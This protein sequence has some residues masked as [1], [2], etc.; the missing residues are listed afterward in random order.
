MNIKNTKYI[1]NNMPNTVSVLLK[2]KHGVG[3]S[4]SVQQVAIENGWDFYDVRLSQCEVGDIKG[5]PYRDG[6][7]MKFA[8][9]EWFPKDPNSKGILF[10]DELNRA[11]KDVLQAVFELCLDRRLDGTPLPEGWRVVAAINAD[12]EYDVVELDP[13]LA[14]RWFHIDFEPTAEE[15]LTWAKDNDIIPEIRQFI[16]RNENLLDP[17]VGNLEINKVYPSRRSWATLSKTI[18]HMNLLKSDEGMFVQVT[19]GFVGTEV[20]IMLQRFI[21]NEYSRIK[22]SDVLD[23]FE[24]LEESLIESCESIEVIAELAVAVVEDA[25]KRASAKFKDLQK[26]NLQKFFMILPN[27]VASNVWVKLL[28]GKRTKKLVTEWDSEEFQAK[29]EQVFLS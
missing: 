9:P 19:K 7:L 1:L 22:P 18:K 17:P 28:K 29:I 25:N 20:A 10:L 12:D 11:T 4:R 14:D 2:A 16:S 5:L 13:A 3:K 24:E 21:S 15:W 27:D 23:K 8:K 26:T 6:D